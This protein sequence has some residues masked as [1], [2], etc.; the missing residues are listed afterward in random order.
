[1][2]LYEVQRKN[3]FCCNSA[4]NAQGSRLITVVVQVRAVKIYVSA[5]EVLRKKEGQDETQF[6]T[7]IDGF[8]SITPP[9]NANVLFGRFFLESHP[10]Y[11]QAEGS[12]AVFVF[13]CG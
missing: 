4:F 11:D 10:A 1:M 5:V 3:H 2:I 6:T 9:L 8:L 12:G 13:L 7:K